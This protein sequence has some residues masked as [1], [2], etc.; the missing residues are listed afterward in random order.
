MNYN[1]TKHHN[2]RSVYK[3]GQVVRLEVR[4]MQEAGI[5]FFFFLNNNLILPD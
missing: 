1:I 3:R 4:G 5:S 2:G